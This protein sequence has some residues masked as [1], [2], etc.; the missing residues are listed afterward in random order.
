MAEWSKAVVLKTIDSKGSGGSNP[1]LSAI[2][3]KAPKWGFFNYGV[4]G[5]LDENPGFDKFA[6]SEFARA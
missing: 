1:S 6:G 4:A 3:K 5:G 2:I